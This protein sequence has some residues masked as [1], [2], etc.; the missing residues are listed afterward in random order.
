M[1]LVARVVVAVVLAHLLPILRRL[2]LE[3]RMKATQAELTQHRTKAA[4]VVVLVKQA[5][6]MVSAQ[7]ATVF[8]H[9]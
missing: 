5:T 7:V 4:V 6:R 2:V 8:L 1:R 3:Q 9:R